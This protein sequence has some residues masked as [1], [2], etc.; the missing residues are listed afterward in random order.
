M[1]LTTTPQTAAKPLYTGCPQNEYLPE[2]LHKE[3]RRCPWAKGRS[4]FHIPAQPLSDCRVGLHRAMPEL[5]VFLSPPRFSRN[6]PLSSL[7]DWSSWSSLK[8]P[9]LSPSAA[10]SLCSCAPQLADQL[11]QADVV[12]LKLVQAHAH[13]RRDAVQRPC[14]CLAPAREPLLRDVVCHQHREA[15]VRVHQQQRAQDRVQR[16]VE[17]AGRKRCQRQGDNSDG[18]EAL[19]RPVVGA[20]AR[21]RRRNGLGVVDY[22][23]S[24]VVGKG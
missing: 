6:K 15:E 4:R 13:Q 2:C 21:A 11:R 10:Q 8:T 14:Q 1:H 17:R 22:K 12:C 3:N 18:D 24:V 16:R 23:R 7:R 9:K 19:K 5:P 20:V